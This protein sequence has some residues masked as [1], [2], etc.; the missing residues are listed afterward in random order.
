MIKTVTDRYMEILKQS[1]YGENKGTFTNV[2]P[3]WLNL[4][5]NNRVYMFRKYIFPC[6]KFA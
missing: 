2:C 4:P 1:Y 5:R 3:A 6:I